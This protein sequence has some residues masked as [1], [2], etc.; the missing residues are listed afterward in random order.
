M[1]CR[2]RIELIDCV[3][4]TLKFETSSVSN[5]FTGNTGGPSP[6]LPPHRLHPLSEGGLKDRVK[7]SEGPVLPFSPELFALHSGEETHQEHR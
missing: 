5:M 2:V 1:S 4:G 7:L 6:L 3:E